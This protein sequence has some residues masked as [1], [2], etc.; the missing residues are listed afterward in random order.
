METAHMENVLDH[1]KNADFMD[2]AAYYNDPLSGLDYLQYPPHSPFGVS[3]M[4]LPP[5][6]SPRSFSSLPLS[7]GLNEYTY[8]SPSGNYSTG[9]PARPYTPTT[10]Y[11]NALSNLSAGDLSSDSVGSTRSRRGSG[12]HSPGPS[13]PP[14]SLA[15]IP[16]SH[17]FNPLGAAATIRA[18]ARQQQ[19]KKRSKA[20]DEFASD[21]DDDFNPAPSAANNDMRR[22]EIRRQR[23]ESEQRRRDELRDGYRRLKDALPVSNQ[24]SSKVSL[25]D[26]AT[27]HIRYLEMTQQQLQ[28]RLQQAEAETAHLR[29]VNEA[30]M[31]GTAE[32]RHAAAASAVAAAQ[33]QQQ[34][35]AVAAAAVASV[36]KY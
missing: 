14:G 19:Q 16:R 7:G 35:V 6:S 10:I 13:V 17:R 22:E 20:S 9:S 4:G 5:T 31:L 33:V 15:A 24:K 30:L 3:S 28:T 27:T 12:S 8:T 2:T 29:H 11:P 21:D 32:Q 23:I 18:S 1:T 26:R 36:N 25:L 34:N